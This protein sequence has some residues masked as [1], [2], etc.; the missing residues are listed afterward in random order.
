MTQD[1]INDM[2]KEAGAPDW[3]SGVG[4]ANVPG[5][6]WLARFAALVAA[7]ERAACADLCEDQDTGQDML[8]DKAVIGCA[9][10]IRARSQQ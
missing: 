10:A 4:D 1:E 7:K 2:A 8:S 3:W 6:K 9:A 5:R